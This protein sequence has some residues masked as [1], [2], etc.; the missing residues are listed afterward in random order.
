MKD[1][2]S[3]DGKKRLQV[4]IAHAGIASRREAEK[5]IEDGKVKVDG[6]VVTGKGVKVDPS[7]QSIKVKGKVIGVEE[8]KYYFIFNKPKGVTS[9]VKDELDRKKVADY[10][11]GVKA[12]LYPI[13][14]L[15]KD[16]TGLLLMTND[17]DVAFK[18]SHSRF[19]VDKE[20]VATLDELV[21]AP[22]IKK[23]ESGIRLDR[24]RTAPCSITPTTKSRDCNVYKIVIHEGKKRQ[25]RRM[26]ELV[27]RKVKRLRRT[28]YLFFNLGSLPEGK[29]RRLSDN[30]II[31]LKKSI[32]RRRR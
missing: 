1:D 13:G 3:N 21:N 23:L 28:K 22:D 26:F 4:I 6:Q 24:K 17:G 16:T 18:L 8:K 15:D 30:E 27:G 25:I 9:T 29:F 19:K 10:F 12:R 11:K 20:Y 2:K 32:S 5:L 7:K 31:K 14:R